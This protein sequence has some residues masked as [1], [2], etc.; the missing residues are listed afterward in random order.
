MAWLTNIL[1][2]LGMIDPLIF[3]NVK[4]IYR[5]LR[6]KIILSIF[7]VLSTASNRIFLIL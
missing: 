7:H 5:V 3:H 6:K 2:C 1:R 4:T